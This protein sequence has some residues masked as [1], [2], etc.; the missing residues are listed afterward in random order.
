MLVESQVRY[1]RDTAAKAEI[2]LCRESVISYPLHTHA[3]VFTAGLVLSGGV[4]FVSGGLCRVLERGQAFWVPPHTPHRMEAEEPYSLLCLCLSAALCAQAAPDV[5]PDLPAFLPAADALCSQA[6]LL[7]ALLAGRS[8]PPLPPL[9]GKAARRREQFPEADLRI[10]GLARSACMSESH[11]IRSFRHA[12]GLTPR[13]FQIQNRVRKAQRILDSHG[14]V[15]EAA[16][17]AGF[18]DQSHLTRHFKRLVGLT[19]AVYRQVSFE[20]IFMP[21]GSSGG[22]P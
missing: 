1:I 18:Y 21:L 4:R 2:I 7:P 8:V 20:E 19:P 16:L 6:L 12:V 15:V 14:S 5:F 11:F 22:P 17:S 13:Q 9:I 10:S 3:S